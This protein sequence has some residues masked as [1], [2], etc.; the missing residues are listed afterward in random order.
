MI[1]QATFSAEGEITAESGDP[2]VIDAIEASSFQKGDMASPLATYDYGIVT[3]TLYL[4]RL[5]TARVAA[6]VG[7][8]SAACAFMPQPFAAG[9]AVVILTFAG[10]AQYAY[11]RG[12]CLKIK[13][14]G[15]LPPTYWPDT[16]DGSYCT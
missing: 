14:L 15:A 2:G 3:G 6:G 10:T 11:D 12:G 4:N 8:A 7:A 9:C 1:Y 13:H 16:H 5:E